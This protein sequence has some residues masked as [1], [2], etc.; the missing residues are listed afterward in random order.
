MLSSVAW[1]QNSLILILRILHFS[2]V[3]LLG[4]Y[5]EGTKFCLYDTV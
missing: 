4:A 5:Q 2:N 3:N 1:V